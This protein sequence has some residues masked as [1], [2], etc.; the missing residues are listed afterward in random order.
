[1]LKSPPIHRTPLYRARAAYKDMLQRCNNRNGKN[2]GYANVELQMTREEWLS[3]SLPLYEEFTRI[4]GEH[5]SPSVSRIGDKGHYALGNL[6]IV[7]WSEHNK[8][9]HTLVVN[10]KKKCS[11][12][13]RNRN[14]DKFTKN[15][16]TPSGLAGQC[17][18]CKK[19]TFQKW[20]TS[21]G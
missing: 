21:K 12:C 20:Y 2:P 6:E 3:W 7:K 14:A 4:H 10:G 15:R 8:I 18:D 19:K 11:A 17:R 5:E 13:G 9:P 1:M 16:T